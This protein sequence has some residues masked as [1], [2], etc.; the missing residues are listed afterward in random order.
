MEAQY[1][2]INRGEGSI[3]HMVKEAGYNPS[4]S[5]SLLPWSP[6]DSQLTMIEKNTSLSVTVLLFPNFE[7]FS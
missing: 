2:S 4:V 5:C 6:G 1:R 3:Y 7:R